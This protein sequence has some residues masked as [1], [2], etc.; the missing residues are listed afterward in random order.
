MIILVYPKYVGGK[1]ISNCLALSR[2]CVVQDRQT[3]LM[4]IKLGRN[5]FT[6]TYYKFKLAAVMKTLP[7][8]QD[9]I[10]WGRYEY[11]CD[12]LYG[13]DEEFYK[14]HSIKAISWK[15]QQD[16]IY[17]TLWECE[18]DSCLITHDYRTLMKYLLVWPDAKVIEFDEYDSFRAIAATLKTGSET[19]LATYDYNTADEYYRQDQRFYRLDSAAILQ[20]DQLMPREIDRLQ[21]TI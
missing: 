6:D 7:L 4:D 8:K 2:H 13:I 10:N 5:G 17:P 16:D 21:K 9:M 14:T 15:I 11:G 12:K 19:V 18:R 1:F 20:M 3:A